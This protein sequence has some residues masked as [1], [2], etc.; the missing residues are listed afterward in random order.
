MRPG[1]DA[2]IP[3]AKAEVPSSRAAARA[4]APRPS[5]ARRVE[6]RKSICDR[7]DVDDTTCG[8]IAL[9]IHDEATAARLDPVL[10]L[11]VI[12]VESSW[13]TAAVSRKGAH[14]LMQ[15]RRGA[16]RTGSLRR[17]AG[18]R[19][20]APAGGE[21]PRRDPLPGT[22]CSARFRKTDLA[23]VAYN[24]GPHRL[25]SYLR[26]GG[27]PDHLKGYP[28]R[29][30]RTEKALRK[31]L[32]EAGDGARREARLARQERQCSTPRGYRCLVIR[33]MPPM[34]GRSASGMRIRSVRLLVLLEDGHQRCGP[35]LRRSR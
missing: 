11:A 31:A 16:F 14:G 20:P 34:Y 9:A 23:L 3:P 33:S 22:A 32:V 13:D 10:V 18:E 19:R 27:V 29:V 30:R 26:D 6:E 1:S 12:Q 28:K 8:R 2:P 5:A 17:S 35:P 25:C 7:A 15:L 21:R 4:Q 24:A